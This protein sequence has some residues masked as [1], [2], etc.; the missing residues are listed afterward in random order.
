MKIKNFLFHRVS[1]EKDEHW[2][3]LRPSLF[4]RILQLILK[5]HSVVSLEHYLDNPEE[6]SD[7]TLPLATYLRVIH[8][9]VNTKPPYRSVKQE[10]I[11]EGR[12]Y[13]NRMWSSEE[14][15][16][17][18]K[19]WKNRSRATAGFQPATFPLSSQNE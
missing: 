6:Y 10:D 5:S 18:L 1:D 12:I 15:K 13:L 14:R 9:L 17:L 4:R 3:P 16:K 8:Y 7:S 19:N 11:A 2:P